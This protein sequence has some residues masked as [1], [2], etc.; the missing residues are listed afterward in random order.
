GFDLVPDAREDGF[1][2]DGRR[3]GRGQRDLEA[4][5]VGEL[6]RCALHWVGHR[7][8]GKLAVPR[9]S[10]HALPRTA[11]TFAHALHDAASALSEMRVRGSAC[12]AVAWRRFTSA[13][14]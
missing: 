8:C 3:A 1:E 9:R 14:S 11:R 2:V 13:S 6:A 5:A 4:A 7:L 10:L 12:R